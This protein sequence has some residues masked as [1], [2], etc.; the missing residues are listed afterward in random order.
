MHEFHEYLSR[1]LI[2]H[3]KKR[4]VVVWY[5]PKAEFRT[6]IREL[7]GGNDPEECRLD[8]IRVGEVPARLCEFKGSFFEVK[9]AVELLAEKSEPEPLLIY[10]PGV[11][12]ELLD[13]P[14]MELEKEDH[15]RE[16][17]LLKQQARFALRSRYSDGVIDGMLASE[18]VQYEDI[19]EL[20]AEREGEQSM[21][22]VI[23]S[24]LVESA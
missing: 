21:P 16:R 1:Q 17:F 12:R 2:E 24:D 9:F 4:R 8:E 5:D 6:Y 15:L 10:V 23:L 13:S 3:L 20:L 18:N 22:K 19:I 7:R 11:E 14:L